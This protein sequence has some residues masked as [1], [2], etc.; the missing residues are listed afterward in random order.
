M[1]ATATINDRYGLPMSTT[2][3]KAAEHY[4]EG[5]DILLEQGYGTEQRFLQAIDADEGFALPYAG[6]SMMQM[7]RGAPAEAK[8]SVAKAQQL[9]RSA[10]RREQGHVEGIALFI[11][12]H[13]PKSLAVTLEHLDEF[14]RDAVMMRVAN[15]LYLLGC[16]GAG[17]QNFP[18]EL[19]AMLQ[20]L[21]PSYGDDWAFLGQYSFAHHETGRL[22]EALSLAERSL[23]AAPPAVMPPTP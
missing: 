7:L 23:P 14:P 13:G 18:D 21:E 10:T 11:N 19:Y 12:G 16:S 17:V 1:T 22:D 4:V 9:V 6:L 20:K 2:S 3:A 5:V 15:R 8:A